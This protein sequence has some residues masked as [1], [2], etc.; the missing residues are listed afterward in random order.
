[1][2]SFTVLLPIHKSTVK[3]YVAADSEIDTKTA[4]LPIS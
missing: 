2:L 3:N 4:V 1:L